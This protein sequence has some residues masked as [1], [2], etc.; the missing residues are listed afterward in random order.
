[1][2]STKSALPK[3]NVRVYEDKGSLAL[4]FSTKYNP[5]FQ[6]LTGFKSRQKCMGLGMADTPQNWKKAQAIALQIEADLEHSD[7]VKLFD[8]TFAKYG[9]GDAKFAQKLA[10]V[11][12]MPQTKTAM[13]VGEMWEDY[14]VW[15][16]GQV[17]PT[18]FKGQF[19][20]T[21]TNAIKGLKWDKKSRQYI[22]I[23]DAVYNLP[24]DN[25][26][27][28]K[29][30]KLINCLIR[31]EAAKKTL[32]ALREAY[33]RA[34]NLGKIPPTKNPFEVVKGEVNN[35]QM[36]E[37]KQDENGVWREWWELEDATDDEYL[38]DTRYF[39]I[40]ERDAII[41]AFYE[42]ESEAKRH[43]APLIE[44]LFLT[45]CRHGEAFA[46]RWKDVS[47]ERG[48]VRF[49]KS[50]NKQVR[51][52]QQTKTGTIRMFKL[53]PKLTDLLLRIQANS[54]KTGKNDLVFTLMNGNAYGSANLDD[55]W[56]QSDASYTNIKGEKTEYITLG[57]VSELA[58]KGLIESYLIPYSTRHTFITLQAQTGVDVALIAASCGNSIEVIYKHY[59]GF[60][61]SASFS[62]L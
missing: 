25:T 35:N 53:Y 1:M 5:V 51:T 38:K 11:I 42:S 21:Y 2:V 26:I 30:T 29:T 24:L 46:L 44:F 9:I 28:E 54:S 39:T 27:G 18:T 59:L 12:Q 19:R 34:V 15:K 31:P 4:R 6:Q 55:V 33:D 13:T 32:S 50:W 36:Y 8:P 45:G 61:K 16:E 49:S 20:S 14:L 37:P 17:Q 43:A 3:A 48:Y 40:T 58:K 22:S 56:R 10:D 52:T 60:N 62:D 47:F 41:K 57:I 7:W 23:S